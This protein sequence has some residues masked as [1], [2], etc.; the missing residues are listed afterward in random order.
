M[1]SLCAMNR[2]SVHTYG[3]TNTL[4][5]IDQVRISGCSDMGWGIERQLRQI[6]VNLIE[7]VIPT[8]YLENIAIP[9]LTYF[10]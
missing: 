10:I 2:L 7:C 9:N 1:K 3:Q 6:A 5:A 8:S 4:T